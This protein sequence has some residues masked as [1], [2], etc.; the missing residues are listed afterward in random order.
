MYSKTKKKY[1]AYVSK[2]KSKHEKQVVLLIIPNGE[3]WNYIAVKQV[4]PLSTKHNGNFSCSTCLHSFRIKIILESHNKVC[5]NKGFF[6]AE[7]AVEY[8]IVW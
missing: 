7:M 2:Q 1:P 6:S 4:S 5:E 3:R 8:I